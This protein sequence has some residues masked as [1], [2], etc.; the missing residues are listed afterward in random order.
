MQVAFALGS[1]KWV[2]AVPFGSPPLVRHDDW[3]FAYVPLQPITQ[4]VVTEF[5]AS[6]IFPSADAPATKPSTANRANR[7]VNP[8]ISILP[9]GFSGHPRQ[10]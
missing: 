4:V 7:I 10:R 5:C 3:Q 6:R 8:R 9:L 1:V 2:T